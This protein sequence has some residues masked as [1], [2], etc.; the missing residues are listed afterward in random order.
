MFIFLKDESLCGLKSVI[1]VDNN[2]CKYFVRSNFLSDT[3]RLI[4]KD[5]NLIR[6]IKGFFS[7]K[8]YINCDFVWTVKKRFKKFKN[9]FNYKDLTCKADSFL[10]DSFKI[11]D[12][13]SGITI[14]HMKL[15]LNNIFIDIEDENYEKDTITLALAVRK[16]RDI[17]FLYYSCILFFVLKYLFKR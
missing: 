12:E 2:D 8:V 6:T 13:S 11:I 3:I 14:G 5:E 15:G 9:E 17:L 16:T 1:K 4:D 10:A 7:P